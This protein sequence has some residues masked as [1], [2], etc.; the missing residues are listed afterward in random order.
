M[1]PVL[2]TSTA[3]A[4]VAALLVLVAVLPARAAGA[5]LDQVLL[6]LGEEHARLL[7]VLDAPPGDLSSGSSPAL[8][9]AP[10]RAT[11]ILAGTEVS[12]T[13]LAAYR[14]R[15]GGAEMPVDQQGVRQL[16]FSEVDGSA[17]VV[18]ELDRARALSVEEV[19]ERALLVDIRVPDAPIDGSLPEARALDGWLRGLSMV[20][21]ET[22]EPRTRPRI[23]VDP[24]H[25]GQDPGAVGC[26]GTHESDVVLAIARRVAAGLERELQAEVVLTRDDDTFI[27]LQDRASLANARDADLFLSIHA[28]ASTADTVWGIE[29]YYLDVAT[30][31]NA[32]AVARRENASFVSAEQGEDAASRVVSDLVV[33]GTS[34]LSRRLAL[35]VQGSV[36]RRLS[37]VVG[38]E[39]IRDLGVKS[40]MFRVLVSTRMPSILFEASFLTHPDDEMRLRTPAFQRQ[41]ANAIVEGVRAY[42][43]A[44]E[45]PQ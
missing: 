7:L 18:V 5:T 10:A 11:L 27:S 13:L 37:L 45:T 31:A 16:V 33:S 1:A 3:Q 42:L 21:A 43:A 40:A 6:F 22:R 26:T 9:S 25:G 8:G 32:A 39:N 35:E 38:A 20:P 4:L 30:D 24:G 36:I 29:T 19:G 14:K 34:A 17:Q 15:P 41:T 23:V 2:P 12:P 44:T 28:N